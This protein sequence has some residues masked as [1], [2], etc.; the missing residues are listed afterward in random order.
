MPLPPSNLFVAG[1]SC[2]NFSRACIKA[3][4]A[5]N[6]ALK[7]RQGT[8]GSTLKGALD[9]LKSDQKF[10]EEVFTKDFLDKYC[11]LKC[12]EIITEE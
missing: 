8:S 4:R 12:N 9:S 5:D 10:L 7:E 2:K 1:T 11:E 3:K 6:N